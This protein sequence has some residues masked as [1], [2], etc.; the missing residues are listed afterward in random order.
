MWVLPF[1]GTHNGLLLEPYL[2]LKPKFSKDK[3]GG[4]KKHGV[5]HKAH[6]ASHTAES[7]SSNPINLLNDF[8]NYFQDKHGQEIVKDGDRGHNKNDV[9]LSKFAGFLAYDNAKNS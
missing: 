9:L 4:D 2:E 8:V 7:F 6:L 1:I 3:R 5:N